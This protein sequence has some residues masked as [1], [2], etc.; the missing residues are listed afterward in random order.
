M[1]YFSV[2][3]VGIFYFYGAHAT[4]NAD[5]YYKL[6]ALYRGS[7]TAFVLEKEAANS[8]TAPALFKSCIVTDINDQKRKFDDILVVKRKITVRA[9]NGPLDPTVYNIFSVL[10]TRANLQKMIMMGAFFEKDL[11]NIDSIQDWAGLDYCADAT[12]TLDLMRNM[13]SGLSVDKTSY[14]IRWNCNDATL[15]RLDS[16]RVSGDYLIFSEVYK[17]Q[18]TYGYCWK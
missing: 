14:E 11:L 18:T 1:K 4:S 2:F 10:E 13:K 7:S 15:A 5:L 8:A 3:L 16:H 17:G 6:E 12:S 9:D